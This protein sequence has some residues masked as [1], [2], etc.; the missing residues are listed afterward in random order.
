MAILNYLKTGTYTTVERVVYDS[1]TK[2]C[3]WSVSVYDSAERNVCYATKE[4][5][6]GYD[7]AAYALAA[8]EAVSEPPENPVE[9]QNYLIG[10]NA[11]TYWLGQDGQ[12][13]VFQ[14]G[15]WGFWGTTPWTIYYCDGK[16]YKR[17]N[18]VFV[19]TEWT[20]DHRI[21]DA[22]F[23]REKVCAEGTNVIRQIYLFMQ[24]MMSFRGTVGDV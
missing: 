24:T 19:E 15:N 13:A 17:V 7:I 2:S 21:W 8:L 10:P 20:L 6:V 12:I 11:T 18:N 16:Y 4:I 5:H 3:V 1:M 22:F 23:T 14:N 9:G